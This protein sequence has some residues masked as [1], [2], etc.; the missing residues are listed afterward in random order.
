MLESVKRQ[1][2]RFGLFAA[3]L[4][5]CGAAAAPGFGQETPQA[6]AAPA[7]TVCPMTVLAPHANAAAMSW[8]AA[9]VVLVLTLQVRPLV[10]FRTLDGV[11][12]ALMCLV[13]PLRD[14]LAACNLDPLG[15]PLQW[16]SYALLSIFGL[17][18]LARG[19]ML[20]T[21]ATHTP[22]TANLSS[23]ASFVVFVA[24]VALGGRT[25]ANAPI[26]DASRD[27]VIGGQHLAQTGALPYG[28]APGHDARSPLLYLLHAGAAKLVP[29]TVGA[30]SGA[31]PEA[32]T[33]TPE[34]AGRSANASAAVDARP[35]RL[36][37]ALLLALLL[38]AVMLAGA[39]LHSPSFGV[40]AAALVCLLPGATEC[41][42][43]PEIMLPAT[44]LAW[45]L[46][47]AT[48][49]ALG[50][51][52]SV[53]TLL[54]AGVAWPWAWLALPGVLAYFLRRGWQAVGAVIGLVGGAAAVLASLPALVAPSLPRADGAL[55]AAGLQPAYR[56][57]PTVNGAAA[58]ERIETPPSPSPG[59]DARLWRFL[60][61]SEEVNLGGAPG[62]ALPSGVSERSVMYRQ[63]LVD[64]AVVPRVQEGYRAALAT[65]PDT[66]R[67]WVALRTI[68]ESVARPAAPNPPPMLG[69]W[70]YWSAGADG[71]WATVRLAARIVLTVLALFAAFVLFGAQRAGLHQLVG[72]LL[73]VSVGALLVSDVGAATNW[74]AAVPLILAA[75]LVNTGAP[76]IP[77]LPAP[78]TVELGPAPRITVEK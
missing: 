43:R 57:V 50:G 64:P 45:S 72:A 39:R 35:A 32:A 56:A 41:F 63:L 74:V 6:A 53:A 60:V 54:L 70:E 20:M 13:M 24:A 31:A 8:L 58:I 16:W 49:P 21:T 22:R 34:A 68:L 48:L 5:L 66:T 51:L 11:V 69:A 17:Y 46:A 3:A 75:M 77:P 40:S 1:A 42:A 28:D 37:N 73:S 59:L 26:S 67:M 27:G 71:P 30:A 18:W 2:S 52:L 15:R 47:F 23:V 25:I 55:S 36:A 4:L 38:A 14:E 78:E 76:A 44:L 62:I 65:Q 12:L 19:V 7:A 61:E 9:V 29:P 33:T 10:C